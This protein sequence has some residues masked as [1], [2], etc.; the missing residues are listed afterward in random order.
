MPWHNMLW[1]SNFFNLAQIVPNDDN[2]EAYF[3]V[4]KAMIP[5]LCLVSLLKSNIPFHPASKWIVFDFK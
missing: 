5:I 4:L 2:G 1:S 3:V